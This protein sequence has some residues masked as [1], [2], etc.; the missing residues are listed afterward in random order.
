MSLTI[1][2]SDL[3]KLA[4]NCPYH[5][6]TYSCY[7]CLFSSM[8]HSTYWAVWWEGRH[9]HW[10]I[11]L[12]NAKSRSDFPPPMQRQDIFLHSD[13]HYGPDDLTL[14]P[15]PFMYEY[16]HLGAIP[17]QPEDSKNPLSIMWWNLTHTHF[18]PLESGVFDR[19]GQ[20]ST[21]KYW[22]NIEFHPKHSPM[23][24]GVLHSHV[25]PFHAFRPNS[26]FWNI[27]TLRSL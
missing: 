25:T 17:R 9:S 3:L 14:W 8:L 15:Q 24:S 23:F 6:S 26:P 16:H 21:S 22:C 2:N 13:F 10:L 1:S 20:L 27:N 7:L 19:I 12:Y 18:V 4:K 11:H 5:M